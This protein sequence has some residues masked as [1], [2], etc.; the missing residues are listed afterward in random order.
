MD[1]VWLQFVIS[2]ATAG[3]VATGFVWAIKGDTKVLKNRLDTIDM[4]LAKMD[5]VLVV[6]AEN[7]G[8]MDL[9]G[10][11]LVMT[12]RRLDDLQRK[13]YNEAD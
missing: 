6:L 1:P 2:L 10:A 8:R 3:V 5:N 11:Q 12:G 7:K 9:L 13:V 4:Q